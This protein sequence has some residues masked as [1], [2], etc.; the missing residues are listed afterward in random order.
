MFRLP[1]L[2]GTLSGACGKHPGTACRVVWDLTHDKAAASLTS[3]YLAG[4]VIMALRIAFIL[5]L[6]LIAR[7]IVHRMIRKLTLRGANLGA[8]RL[9]TAHLLRGERRHQRSQALGSVLSNASSVIIFGIAGITIAGD[10]GV[11]LAPVLASA[12]VLGIAVGFGAQSLVRDFLA[13][14]FMLLEDQYGVGDV[15]D[16]GEATGT[17]E[18]VSLRTTRL[19]DVS[20]I[21]WYVRNGTI[22]RIGN[23]S[24]SWARAVIDFPVPYDHDLGRVREIMKEVALQLWG[25]PRW[26]DLILEE[27]EIWGVELVYRDAVV[28]R[29]VAK[30]LPLRQWEVARELRGRLKMAL[31]LP[32][33]AA[34]PAIAAP[35]GPPEA[36]AA[37]AAA[38]TA[39]TAPTATGAPAAA[40][41]PTTAKP[42]GSGNGGAPAADGSKPAGT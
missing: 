40:A 9:D 3:S 38:A 30:T 16:A 10:L 1:G 20:G 27:P 12:G 17:V 35:A 13:G 21:V 37:A 31:D 11:N 26:H 33:G 34:G 39:V 8:S 22:N 18:A 4:P 7:A 14:I 42:A 32:D 5:V 36:A 23:K 19:R 41:A 29:L 2:G 6:A 28:M 15:I 25:E 24:Q